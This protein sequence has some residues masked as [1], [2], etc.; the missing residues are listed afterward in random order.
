M[1]VKSA[2]L[3]ETGRPAVLRQAIHAVRKGGT[4]LIPGAYSS[5]LDKIP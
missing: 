3:L 1:I 5:L 4:V 2:L